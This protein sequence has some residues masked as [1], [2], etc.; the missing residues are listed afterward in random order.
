MSKHHTPVI[1]LMMDSWDDYDSWGSASEIAG[2][3]Y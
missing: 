3:S 2:K 1:A